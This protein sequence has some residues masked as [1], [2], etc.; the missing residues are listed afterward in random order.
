LIFI[1]GGSLDSRPSRS[2]SLTAGLRF[3]RETVVPE[4]DSVNHPAHYTAGIECFDFISSHKMSFAQGNVIKYVT[5]YKQK[6]GVEDLKKARWYL[7]KLIEETEK[8]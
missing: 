3:Q 6:N 2:S 4:N 8:Q 5:R 7:E 1:G